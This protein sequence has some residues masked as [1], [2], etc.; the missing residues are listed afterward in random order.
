M[1]RGGEAKCSPGAAEQALGSGPAG[2]PEPNPFP[3]GEAEAAE[4]G[5]GA[6]G[7]L[8]GGTRGR[9]FA[10]WW[11]QPRET[12]P[13]GGLPTNETQMRDRSGCKSSNPSS[14]TYK[15]GDLAQTPS[16][17]PALVSPSESRVDCGVYSKARG[18]D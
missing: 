5:E 8:P 9:D 1:S 12:V 16:A 13:E 14:D 2:T 7:H 6:A 3:G 15:T 4:T 11:L 18:E 10:S 17:L